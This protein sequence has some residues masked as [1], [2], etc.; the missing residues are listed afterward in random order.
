MEKF[1][2]VQIAITI[3]AFIIA[4]FLTKKYAKSIAQ[5]A[6]E[7]Y[8]SALWLGGIAIIVYAPAAIYVYHSNANLAHKSLIISL[9]ILFIVCCCYPTVHHIKNRL[10]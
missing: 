5:K 1:T 4:M 7:N 10:T 8:N 9:F 3:I 2:V 6:F